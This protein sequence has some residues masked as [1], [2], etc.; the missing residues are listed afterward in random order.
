MSF[1][2]NPLLVAA[3]L[4]LGISG[5]AYFYTQNKTEMAFIAPINMTASLLTSTQVSSIT[6][7]LKSFG[8][9][10]SIVENVTRALFGGSPVLSSPQGI[11][12]YTVKGTNE[13]FVYTMNAD[14]T[15]VKPVASCG[16]GECFPSWSFDGKK[17][18]FSRADGGSGIYTMNADGTNLKRLSPIPGKDVTPTF[19][20][21]GTK[22]IFTHVVAQDPHGGVPT[23]EIMTMSAA[24]GSN[25]TVVIPALT[26][27]F[28]VEAHYSP[29][30]KKIVFMRATPS[31]GQHVYVANADGTGIKQ[32]TYEG[33]NGDPNWSPDGTRISFGSNREGGGKLNVF[34]MKADGTDVKQITHFN[35]PY[36]A[37]DTSWSPDGKYITFEWDFDGKGQSDP[38]VKAEVWI[39]ASD[40]SGEPKTTGQACAAVGCAPRWRP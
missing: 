17:I 13:N 29:D 27:G 40:G 4:V 3:T 32:V 36:E 35:P 14:G 19:S 7:L 30:G 12:S 38:N 11:I 9:S 1:F 22:V 6:S 5:A 8:A 31:A 20:P 23:T 33:V 18:T 24:D 25:R 16:N 39:V 34:T 26:G 2:R 10:Q 21:D 37:G 28:S 15:G